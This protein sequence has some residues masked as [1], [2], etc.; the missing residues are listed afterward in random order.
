VLGLV[1]YFMV[2]VVSRSFE[3]FDVLFDDFLD[4][5]GFVVVMM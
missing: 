1:E 3:L 2:V 4:V 5:G